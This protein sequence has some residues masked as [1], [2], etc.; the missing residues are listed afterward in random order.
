MKIHG[1]K[2]TSDLARAVGLNPGVVRVL[3]IRTAV[4]EPVTIR[5]WGFADMDDDEAP[6]ELLAGLDWRVYGADDD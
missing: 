3:E 1:H 5:A 4:D 6:I 2:F